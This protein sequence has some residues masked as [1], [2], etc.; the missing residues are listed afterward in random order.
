[1]E[2]TT[3]DLMTKEMRRLSANGGLVGEAAVLALSGKKVY[4]EPIGADPERRVLKDGEIIEFK[5]SEMTCNNICFSLS[6]S[7]EIWLSQI[8]GLYFTIRN[9]NNEYDFPTFITKN[10]KE[11]KLDPFCNLESFV[12][13]VK[14]K[15][16]KVEQK[17]DFK[18]RVSFSGPPRLDCAK[19]HKM[20]WNVDFKFVGLNNLIAYC[21]D[22]LNSANYEE[23]GDGY[24]V[25]GKLY[26]FYEV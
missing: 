4:K 6:E 26:Y 2:Q 14:N 3:K 16:F 8:Q 18:S 10:G 24:L 22:K 20:V 19:A 5:I 25:S 7:C 13:F 1:M 15:K 21:L 12:A 11:I 23:L 9:N 17:V